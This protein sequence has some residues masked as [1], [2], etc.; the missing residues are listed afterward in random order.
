VHQL[1]HCTCTRTL[2]A[3]CD[4]SAAELVSFAADVL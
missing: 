4:L 3:R 2:P 1:A